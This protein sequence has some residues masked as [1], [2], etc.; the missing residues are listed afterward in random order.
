MKQ[1]QYVFLGDPKKLKNFGGHETL[2]A[3]ADA[4]LE[5][6]YEQK[7]QSC[8]VTVQIIKNRYGPPM[9]KHGFVLGGRKEKSW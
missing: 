7:D 2:M 3:I 5:V 4:V 6:I 1:V 9:Q 8:E